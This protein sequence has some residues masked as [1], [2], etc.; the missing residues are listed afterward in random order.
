MAYNLYV[1]F[2]QGGIFTEN[3]KRVKKDFLIGMS[4]GE[5][6]LAQTQSGETGIG[7]FDVVLETENTDEGE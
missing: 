7:I 3:K 1:T 4:P 2:L 6:S 5:N